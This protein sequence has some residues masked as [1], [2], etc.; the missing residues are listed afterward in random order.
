VHSLDGA[1][2]AVMRSNHPGITF[3]Y[4]LG[5][6]GR[7]IVY[8]TD[9]ELLPG[10][11]EGRSHIPFNRDEFRRFIRGA[12]LLIHDAQYSD[13]EYAA[14]RGW[15]HSPWKEA[16][17]LGAEGEVKHLI[18]F[19]HDPDHTDSFI[20]TQ[21]RECRMIIRKMDAPMKCSAAQE[22]KTICL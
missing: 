11:R 3:S 21:V 19:H 6:D 16:V 5:F 2:L 17:R 15:G 1:D 14:K 20:D 9:N 4:A 18:L 12:D 13:R 8:M 22:G 7:K 10:A